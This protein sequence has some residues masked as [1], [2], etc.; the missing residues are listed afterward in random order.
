MFCD[1]CRDD[2]CYD[3]DQL[4]FCELCN[5]GVHQHCYK[6]DLAKSVPT[7]DWFCQRCLNLME[8]DL[9]PDSISCMFCSHLTGVMVPI[10]NNNVTTWV[11]ITCVNWIKE[12]YF[13]DITETCSNQSGSQE[14]YVDFYSGSSGIIEGKLTPE[15]F[16]KEC[17]FC[18]DPG[19][20]IDC[21]FP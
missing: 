9:Q 4:I 10:Q 18:E 5:V 1:I 8:N 11:H 14:E 15:Q 20:C 19:V 7:G 21:D 13:Q 16:Q 3:D 12:I 17:E 6:R 2:F